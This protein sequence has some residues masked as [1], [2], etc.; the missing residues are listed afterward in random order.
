M[1]FIEMPVLFNEADSFVGC[2][3][4]C[5]QLIVGLFHSGDHSEILLISESPK[6]PPVHINSTR[7]LEILRHMVAD[8]FSKYMPQKFASYILHAYCNIVFLLSISVLHLYF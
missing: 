3:I 6:V 8:W 5:Y 4:F 2:R 7:R 1:I